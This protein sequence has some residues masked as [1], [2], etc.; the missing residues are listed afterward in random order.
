MRVTVKGGAVWSG[1][2]SATA[3][4]ELGVHL[5]AARQTS[6]N[7]GDDASGPPQSIIFQAKDIVHLSAD[8]VTFDNGPVAAPSASNN[9]TS[10]LTAGRSSP[11]TAGVAGGRD[12]F[13][14]DTD[15]SGT[16]G[17]RD[18]REL[19][20]WGSQT[21]ADDGGI[22]GS[23]LEDEALE[24]RGGPSNSKGPGGSGKW[25]QFATNERLFGAKTNYQEEFYTTKLDKTG[26]DFR[27]REARAARLAREIESVGRT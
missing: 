15:I 20:R 12:G 14:T 27:E 18:Q 16:S 3:G 25:D 5:R 22:G 19:Q 8:A 6:T 26:A 11:R 1:I 21:A 4:N 7:A 13:R 10:N 9:S 23:S 24:S 2:L 17:L